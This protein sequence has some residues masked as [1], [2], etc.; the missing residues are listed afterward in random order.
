VTNVPGAEL[1]DEVTLLGS[2]G[3]CSIDAWEHARLADT[4]PYE[5]LCGIA[6]RV[7]RVYGH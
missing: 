5:I 1:G 4:I 3:D 2:S 6:K 7:P